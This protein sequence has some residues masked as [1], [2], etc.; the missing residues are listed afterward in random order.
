MALELLTPEE[1]GYGK[2]DW[3]DECWTSISDCIVIRRFEFEPK[4]YW[5]FSEAQKHF[6]HELRKYG[7]TLERKWAGMHDKNGD[8]DFSTGNAVWEVKPISQNRG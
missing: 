8:R 1:S 3:L 6:R 7:W 5:D 4:H 2:P